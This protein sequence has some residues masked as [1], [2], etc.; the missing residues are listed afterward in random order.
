MPGSV[1]NG[2]TYIIATAQTE[3]LRVLNLP[4]H[5]AERRLTFF[6]AAAIMRFVSSFYESL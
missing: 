1:A 6:I 2:T 3:L 4:C 5:F